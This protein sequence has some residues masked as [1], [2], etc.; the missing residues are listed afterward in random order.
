MSRPT[1][2]LI[3][4]YPILMG[5]VD[6]AKNLKLS[7]AFNYFQEM[8]RLHAD[9][10]GVGIEDIELR[11]GGV[12]VLTRMRVDMYRYPVWGEEVIIETWPLVPSKFEFNRDYLMKD[13]KG[14]IIACAVSTWM[15]LDVRTRRP[16]RSEA[17][18][19][20]NPDQDDERPR[21][22]SCTLGK[23]KMP[24]NSVLAYERV[25]GCSDIDS[26]GHLNNSKYLDFIIDCFSMEQLRRCRLVSVQINYLGE[27]FAG[28]TVAL[29]KNFAIP[30]QS[31][32]HEEGIR[33]FYIEGVCGKD[34]SVIFIAR[35]EITDQ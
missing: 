22:I 31:V 19:M 6:F 27:A 20:P 21:A 33:T 9:K 8:A 18:G 25:I 29:Y 4:R 23:L 2:R 30:E 14:K 3:N 16:K 24:V 32:E 17:I 15:V 10:L 1:F 11:H 35:L 7:A 5:D 26:N 34:G 12:W 13:A 28:D